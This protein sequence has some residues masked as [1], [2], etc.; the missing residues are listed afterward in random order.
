MRFRDGRLADPP[1]AGAEIQGYV[2]DAKLRCAE[3]AREVWGDDVAAERLGRE[4]AELRAR[5]D[6]AFWCDHGWYALALDRDKRHVDGLASNIGHLLWSGIALPERVEAIAEHLMGDALWTGL[7]AGGHGAWFEPN[8]R[9]DHLNVARPLSWVVERFLAGLLIAGERASGWP[10][11][12]RLG[13]A[14]WAGVSPAPPGAA[15]GAPDGGDP[16][17]GGGAGGGAAAP[18]AGL[19]ARARS[20]GA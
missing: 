11:P 17:G 13:A 6:T 16:A 3:L 20:S 15:G 12:R 4:A 10:L 18:R 8:A 1:I 19:A 9:I 2:Y 7:R 5:F 14:G